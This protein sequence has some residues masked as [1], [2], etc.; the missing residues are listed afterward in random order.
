MV[1]IK[2]LANN[3]DTVGVCSNLITVKVAKNT[4]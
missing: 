4:T 1:I 3:I 2:K